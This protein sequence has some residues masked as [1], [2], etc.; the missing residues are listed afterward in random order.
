MLP[1]CTPGSGAQVTMAET[2]K[3]LLERLFAE[4]AGA[5]RRHPDA[6]E[7]TQEVYVRM[8]R[9]ADMG[10]IRNPE[11]YLYTVASN[12]GSNLTN[13]YGP[14]NISSAQFIKAN[15]PLRPRVL[16]AEFTYLVPRQLCVADP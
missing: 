16:M 12:R 11:A 3:T 4:H 5:L 1:V 6:A 14:T 15:I 8:L 10:A 13:L 2:K 9:V 7:L